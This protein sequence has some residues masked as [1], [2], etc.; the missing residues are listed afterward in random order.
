MTV[1]AVPCPACGADGAQPSRRFSPEPLLECPVCGFAFLDSSFEDVRGI[2]E[3]DRYFEGY[4]G[5]GYD[6]DAQRRHEARRRLDWVGRHAGLP[7]RV[8]EVGAATGYFLSE[9]AARGCATVGIEPV[10]PEAQRAREALGVDV[11]TGFLGE[12]ELPEAPFDVVCAFHVLEHIPDPLAALRTMRATL[13][14]G[15]HVALEV[16]NAACTVARVRRARWPL[17]GVPHHVNQ[18]GP[19]SLRAAV[20]R[21]GFEV[22][23]QDTVATYWYFRREQ[24]LDPRRVAG[25][26]AL[27]VLSRTWPTGRHATRHELLR[28]IGR[29]AS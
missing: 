11:R 15:G 1:A 19:A 8:L 25:R 16:P 5:G 27:S 28:L 21:A 3:D 6:D 17:L 29:Y 13:R 4:P 9:A 10:A 7:A 26:A 24:A 18:F 14:P 23:T 20:E 22:V 2:Y 12:V